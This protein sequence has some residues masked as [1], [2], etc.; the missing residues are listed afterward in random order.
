MN[1]KYSLLSHHILPKERGQLS[2]DEI[3]IMATSKISGKQIMD[4]EVYSFDKPLSKV[5]QSNNA[6]NRGDNL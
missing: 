4:L 1:K 2:Y 6:P 5:E 3:E